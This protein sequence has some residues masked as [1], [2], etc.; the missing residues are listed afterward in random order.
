MFS[1]RLRGPYTQKKISKTTMAEHL[2]QY[3]LMINAKFCF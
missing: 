2:K 1:E 3:T